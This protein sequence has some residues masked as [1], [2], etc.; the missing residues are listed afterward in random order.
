MLFSHHLPTRTNDVRTI[1]R[2]V[3]PSAATYAPFDERAHLYPCPNAQIGCPFKQTIHVTP[4]P[5]HRSCQPIIVKRAPR[6]RVKRRIKN[7]INQL[8]GSSGR[9]A[10]SCGTI[11]ARRTIQRGEQPISE[12]CSPSAPSVLHSTGPVGSFVTDQYR[13]HA[14]TFETEILPIAR[15]MAD[16]VRHCSS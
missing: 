10:Q 4:C 12:F 13:L 5:R 6:R 8:P 3:G 16:I 9:R 15:M 11:T 1:P 14:E 7:A 2:P